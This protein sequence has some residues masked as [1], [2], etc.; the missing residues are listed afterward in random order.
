MNQVVITAFYHFINLPHFEAIKEPLMKFCKQQELKGTILLAKEGINSTISGSRAA[1]DNLY[2]YLAN[3]IKI[4]NLIYKESFHENQPFNKMK[5]NLRKEIV[6]LGI[7]NLDVEALKGKYIA[8]KEWDDFISQ[9]DVVVIDTRNK[10]ETLLG[11]FTKA[12]DPH[13]DNFKQF[14]QWV[15][16]NLSE[17][18]KDKKIAMFCTGGI[19]CEKSTAYMKSQGFKNVYH[20]EGGILKYFEDTEAKSWHGSC[21]VF[22]DRVALNKQLLIDKD[23]HCTACA[24]ALDTDDIRRSALIDNMIC[25]E[26]VDHG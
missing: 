2:R 13:T 18:A 19:R 4:K 11:S 7:E 26:C 3:E 8:P 20:L 1:I 14:P 12:I 23:L 16:D 10:Y 6:A 15:K 25:L 5:I 22:D 9:E 24:K 21:F 17:V